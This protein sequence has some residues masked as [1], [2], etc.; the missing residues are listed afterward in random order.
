MTSVVN[1]I[2]GLLENQPLGDDLW[3][4]LAWCLGLVVVAYTFAMSVYRSKLA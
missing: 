2:R 1:T 4:A 3:V